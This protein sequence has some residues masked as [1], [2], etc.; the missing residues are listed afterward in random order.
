MSQLFDTEPEVDVVRYAQVALEQAIDAA[1]TGLTYAVPRALAD[2]RI[3][4]RVLAP[5]GRGDRPVAGHVISFSDTTD[6][7]RVKSLLSRDAE[8]VSIPPD[9]VELASWI[10][11]YYC[12]PL[13]MVFGAMLPAAVKQG[14]GKQAKLMAALTDLGR[15]W[16]TEHAAEGAS[17][18]TKTKA[19]TDV[20]IK[21]ESETEATEAT[22]SAKPAAPKRKPVKVKKLTT[23]QDAVLRAAGDIEAE[24]LHAAANKRPPADAPHAPDV[25]VIAD[26]AA[27]PE[28]DH[29]G[30]A[31]TEIKLLADRGGARSIAPVKQLIDKGL[32]HTTLAS[33]VIAR[34]DELLTTAAP[35]AK[36]IKLNVDQDRVV[37]DIAKAAATGFGVHLIHGVTSSGKTEVYLR[38]IEA[39]R[40]AAARAAR[41]RG[42]QGHGNEDGGG[43]EGQG[44]RAE[45]GGSEVAAS[46]VSSTESSGSARSTDSDAAGGDAIGG[47]IVLVPEIAL[48]PQ[49]VSRFLTRFDRVAVLH[50]G[51]TSAQ[52]HEQWQRI[53]RGEADIVIGARSAVFAPLS[54]VALIIVDEEHETSY[55]Q[56]QAPRYHGRD[57]AIKRA[58]MHNAAILLGSAT[59]SLESFYNATARGSY[60]LH[61]LPK[62]AAGQAM[63]KIQI[64]DMIAERRQRRG[65]HLLTQRLE[66]AITITLREK[67]QAILLLNRRGYANYVA[68]P[69][70]RCGWIKSC[71]YCDANMVFHRM[72]ESQGGGLVRCHYCGAEQSLPKLCPQSQHKV[73]TFGLGTQRVEEELATKFPDARLLRMDSDVM[74]TGRDYHHSLER[75]RSG[76]IDLLVGTQMIAKGLD[77]P[78][79]RLVG[80]I[81]G[82]T[83][84]HLPDFRAGERTFQLIAQVAGRAGRGDKSGVVV[85]QTFC[86]DDEVINLAA[87]HDYDAFAAREIPQREAFGLPPAGRMARIVL[88]DI[89][90]VALH[91]RATELAANLKQ[92]NTSLNLDIRLRGPSM[93]AVARIAEHHRMQIEL[94]ATPPQ[95]AVRIQKLLTALRNAKLL[96]SDTHTAVDVDPVDLL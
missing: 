66:H 69:D 58:H 14:V 6:V 51:L 65:I 48:T 85:V 28:D 91:R 75:F 54:K 23:L 7:K 55:K 83:A 87:R 95:P 76:E 29:E 18:D 59:P 64:V 39:V 41:D 42:T 70:Q 72:S 38:V 27:P 71:E 5:L 57:V 80:V 36:P 8:G 94:L 46:E 22:Q 56:D 93:C 60:T 84:L 17:V 45:G 21:A 52:R 1:A 47:V 30:H 86:P 26:N 40:A 11:S 12:C 20:A 89:D 4:D 3:G 25:H 32:L 82:D 33:K 81:S 24:H 74:R 37:N 43:G 62:R 10:A 16:L 15:T 77:F 31:W 92:Y 9:L 63:P 53:R 90:D 44:A 73:T 96:T 35:P 13:G 67:A 68:C 78:N 34:Q 79:V 61:S 49:T 50:S 2:L 88:R 19:D